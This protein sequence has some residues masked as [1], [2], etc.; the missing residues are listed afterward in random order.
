MSRRIRNKRKLK[1]IDIPSL[2]ERL[3]KINVSGIEVFL[4]ENSIKITTG[5]PKQ[6]AN[7][8]YPVICFR[9]TD[10]GWHYT[11]CIQRRVVRW[12]SSEEEDWNNHRAEEYTKLIF[13]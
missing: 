10:V 4:D 8:E 2:I 3:N 11:V 9:G 1:P 7:N 12:T 6:C 13:G 5:Y